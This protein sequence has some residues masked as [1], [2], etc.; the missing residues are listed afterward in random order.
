[1]EELQAREYEQRQLIAQLRAENARLNQ[2]TRAAS[3]DEDMNGAAEEP[4]EDVEM[5]QLPK[6]L[7][8]DALRW[9]KL[10]AACHA[11]WVD[12]NIWDYLPGND[13]EEEE[14]DDEDL[15]ELQ[16][17]RQERT[18]MSAKRLFGILPPAGRKA[19]NHPEF[20]QRVSFV[21]PFTLS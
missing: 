14:D 20:R 17:A 13:G 19:A 7:R 3:A 16:Q 8:R 9:G 18:R 4:S 15:S 11:L 12:A 10:F 2:P 6:Q 5:D 1:M 21:A